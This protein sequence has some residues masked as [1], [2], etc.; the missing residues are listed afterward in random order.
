MA[1]SSSKLSEIKAALKAGKVQSAERQVRRAAL[2]Q[3][4]PMLEKNRRAAEKLVTSFLE[5]SG[6]DLAKLNEIQTLNQAELGRIEEAQRV[7]AIRRSSDVKAAFR[8]AIENRRNIV[9]NISSA[10]TA[11]GMQQQPTV[12]LDE[13]FLI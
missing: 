7:E 6:F 13:P 10:F 1:R 11:G 5:K 12:V 3:G 8:S 9:A 2:V 4:S